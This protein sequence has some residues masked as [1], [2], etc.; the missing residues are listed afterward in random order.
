LRIFRWLGSGILPDRLDLRRCG[1]R[2]DEAHGTGLAPVPGDSAC[3]LLADHGSL[4]SQTWLALLGS[5]QAVR[6]RVLLTTVR[7]SDERARLFN[8]GFGDLVADD[9]G[10]AEIAAQAARIVD[11]HGYRLMVREVGAMRLDL[12]AR[13]GF[14]G[15]RRLAL[16]PREFGLLWRLA[17]QV[18]EWVSQDD[19]LADV[20]HLAGRPP[21]NSLAVHVSRLRAKLRISGFDRLIL[22]GPEGYRLLLGDCGLDDCRLDGGAAI[23]EDCSSKMEAQSPCNIN[24]SQMTV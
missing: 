13:E 12:T 9:A 14:V 11:R 6:A 24:S 15:R 19:L 10:P 20:W 4:S 2:L 18:G 21:T 5:E 7:N 3:L 1:W 22:T 17:Q 8:L 23:S 16:H